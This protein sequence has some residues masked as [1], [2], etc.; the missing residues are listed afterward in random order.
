MR[1][2]LVEKALGNCEVAA[3]AGF[4]NDERARRAG[5]R[6]AV[7]ASEVEYKRVDLKPEMRGQARLPTNM[8]IVRYC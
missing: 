3:T 1:E 7:E 8:A 6:R 4:L 5:V 2:A